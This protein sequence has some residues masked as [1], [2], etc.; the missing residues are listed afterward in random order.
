MLLKNIKVA[1]VIDSRPIKPVLRIA[2]AQ[3][4]MGVDVIDTK[5]RRGLKSIKL[6][7][8]LSLSKRASI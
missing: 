2:G 8:K 4:F 5:G 6:S 1:A 3:I 7:D